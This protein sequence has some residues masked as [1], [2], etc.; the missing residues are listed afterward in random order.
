MKYLLD[1]NAVIAMIRG[2]ERPIAELRKHTPTD[3]A[4]PAS[5]MNSFAALTK[6]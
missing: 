1:A 6:V 2:N 3:F 4:M 5:R